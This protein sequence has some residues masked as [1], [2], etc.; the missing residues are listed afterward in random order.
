MPAEKPH[1]PTSLHDGL[2]GLIQERTTG[3][4]EDI[5]VYATDLAEYKRQ[6]RFEQVKTDRENAVD[7]DQ[8]EDIEDDYS[9]DP[10]EYDDVPESGAYITIKHINDN[11]YYYWQWRAGSD[12]WKNEYIGPVSPS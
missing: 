3:E 1:P 6:Q 11:D 10:D 8:L 9:I 5:A 7:T 12:T 2:I 4:L